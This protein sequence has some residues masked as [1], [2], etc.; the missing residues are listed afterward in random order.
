[1]DSKNKKIIIAIVS[2]L[3]ISILIIGVYVVIKNNKKE[4]EQE[5]TIVEEVEENEISE[6][7]IDDEQENVVDE[8]TENTTIENNVNQ[9][10]QED[11]E[12]LQNQVIGR[13]EQESITE[14]QGPTN[15][16]KVMELVKNK[17][18]ANDDSVT[19]NIM[20]H[21]GDVYMVS[22][23]DKDTT[24]VKTWYQVN[25]STGEVTQ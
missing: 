11:P 25:L 24:A 17:W 4:Q 3:L 22:V 14:N 20:N 18:G 5:N 6:E 7:I 16:E 2:V 1:M 10:I 9:E 23:N 21:D 19:F 15:E 8:Q 13:E 12:Q